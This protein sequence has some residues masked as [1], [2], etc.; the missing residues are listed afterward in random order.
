MM[1]KK[2]YLLAVAVLVAAAITVPSGIVLAAYPDKPITML[3]GFRPGGAVDTTARLLA[4]NMENILG[5][6]IVGV[7]KSG[8]GGTV[9][10]SQLINAKADGYTI[11]MGA[12]AAYTLTPQINTKIKYKIDNFDH[13]ATVTIPQDAIVVLKDSPW[14]TLEDMVKDAKASGKTL[15]IASQV[16]VVNLLALA[17]TNKT[18]VKFKVVP[19][20]GGSRGIQ[21]VLGGHVDV[22]W[23]GSGWHKQIQAGTMKALASVGSKRNV[24]YPNLPTMLELGYGYNFT[25]TFML[26]APKGLPKDVLA[27]LASAVKKSLTPELSAQL[28]SKMKLATDYRGPKETT[29]FL[30]KQYKDI[31]PFVAKLKK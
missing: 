22:T 4:K 2:L 20:K 25:D 30:H 27:K 8:G 3:I 26:S 18:G 12:S 21:A 31:E 5:Q 6:P 16:S 10:A 13:I 9:M 29:A 24:D 1:Y 28:L 23:S 19:V 11:G 14:N 15:S 7:T 17:I